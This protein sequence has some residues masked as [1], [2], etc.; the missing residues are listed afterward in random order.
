M[1]EKIT[2]S[3]NSIIKKDNI[4]P[5]LLDKILGFFHKGPVYYDGEREMFGYEEIVEEQS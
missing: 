2:A 4:S 5:S 1:Y 3:L